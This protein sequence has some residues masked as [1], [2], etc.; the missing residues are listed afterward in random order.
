ML[1]KLVQLKHLAEEEEMATVL[2]LLLCLEPHHLQD[3]RQLLLLLN[4]LQR[5]RNLLATSV[6]RLGETPLTGPTLAVI[7]LL[8]PT[9]SIF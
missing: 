8:R 1:N 5:K 3:L 7:F 4:L 2:L 9:C 6:K